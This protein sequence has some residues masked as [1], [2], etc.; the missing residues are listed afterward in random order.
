MM[1]SVTFKEVIEKTRTVEI[2]ARDMTEACEKLAK[3]VTPEVK[4]F[5]IISIEKEK[6][7]IQAHADVTM[8]TK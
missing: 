1:Y 8:G 4:E 7:D 5:H 6:V 3:L 2:S